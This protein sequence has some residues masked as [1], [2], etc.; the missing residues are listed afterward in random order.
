MG[1][2][3]EAVLK[4][5][6]EW[7]KSAERKVQNNAKKLKNNLKKILGALGVSLS[8]AGLV[9]FS[10]SITQAAIE[11]ESVAKRIN[12]AFS[13]VDDE[14]NR[15][16][17]SLINEIEAWADASSEKLGISETDLKSYLLTMNDILGKYDL[18]KEAVANFGAQIIETGVLMAQDMGVSQA[19]GIDLIT[20][21][22]SGSE[23]ACRK[24][25]INL[26]ENA[27]KAAMAQLGITGSFEAL[28]EGTKMAVNYTA[29][30][31]QL[32]VP[33][34]K[35]DPW[36]ELNATW[37]NLKETLGEFLLPFLKEGADFLAEF[38]GKVEEGADSA[39][40]VNSAAQIAKDLFQGL[41]DVLNGVYKFGNN[42]VTMFGGMGNTLEVIKGIITFIL[43]AKIVGRI[44][45]VGNAVKGLGVAFAP[46]APIA[47][48]VAAAIGAGGWLVAGIG[49]VVAA[50]LD[51]VNFMQGESSV[52]GGILN[53]FGVDTEALRND[54]IEY[55]G[56]MKEKFIE[57]K[58][59]AIEA[60]N[61]IGPAWESYK[62]VWSDLTQELLDE[63]GQ[64]AELPGKALEWGKGIMDNL[65]SAFQNSPLG[66]MIDG[67][68]GKF[69]S[70][71]DTVG[72]KVESVKE[73]AG[74]IKD[75]AVETV[76]EKYNNVKDF[77]VSYVGNVK[78]N[79][80]ISATGDALKEVGGSAL[81]AGK[82]VATGF[83]TGIQ[84]AS[85]MVMDAASGIADRVN[86]FLGFSVPEE[87][88][89]SDQD[90]WGVHFME[91]LVDGL[92][93]GQPALH[94]MILN[95]ANMFIELAE[96]IEKTGGSIQSFANMSTA[97][98]RAI[99][100]AYGSM[101]VIQNNS[102]NNQF[103]GSERQNQV[104]AARQMDRNASDATSGMAH[105]LHVGS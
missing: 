48:K 47:T 75:A 39:D 57:W 42:V 81:E 79:G 52:I 4:L 78:E 54:I 51:F 80:V 13:E 14:G 101:T 102:F 64:L 74:N 85:G 5:K 96:I 72:E 76:T 9:K 1:A 100:S 68:K 38:V 88:P 49:A 21:A 55:F 87:G 16:A 25:G 62:A 90:E 86:S 2:L 45:S 65:V 59:G 99:G 30:L 7:D 18:S 71:K 82:D 89:L 84:N 73:T 92:K 15:V 36:N 28:D 20:S 11:A 67:L 70:L 41:R 26:D 61:N 83:A 23:D 95:I 12:Y 94:R 50:G 60:F 97:S 24:L 43:G 56:D 93:A 35:P 69:E 40:G 6:A 63:I 17:G 8:V 27:K 98:A 105:A 37:K 46:L 91:N 104:A 58:D 31:N 22:I 66:Q 34:P 33:D 19:E 53:A 32:D 29:A 44:F 10:K 103:N 77:S 3:M